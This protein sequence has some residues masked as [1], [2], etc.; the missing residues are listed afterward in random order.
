MKERKENYRTSPGRKT[1]YPIWI[2]DIL[3]GRKIIIR[4]IQGKSPELKDMCF[5]IEKIIKYSVQ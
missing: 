3:E 1:D 5:Q 4:I 2:A